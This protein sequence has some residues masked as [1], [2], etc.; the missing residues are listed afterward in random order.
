MVTLSEG[1]VL[2]CSLMHQGEEEI[3]DDV[4]RRHYTPPTALHPLKAGPGLY[5]CLS[6]RRQPRAQSVHSLKT[7]RSQEE[8]KERTETM[9]AQDKEKKSEEEEEEGEA[10]PPAAGKKEKSSKEV[11][12]SV[13]PDRYEPLI[14]EEEEETAEVRRRRKEEKKRRKKRKYKKYRKNVGRTIRFTLRCLMLG[15]QNMAS[16]YVSPV[17]AATAVVTEVNQRT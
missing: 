1:T 11:Y 7:R 6:A 13:L 14:E 3:G 10:A 15:L 8:K 4:I 9:G 17:S 2:Y 12:F 5:C 16:V